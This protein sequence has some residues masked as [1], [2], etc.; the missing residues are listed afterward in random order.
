MTIR[1]LQDK[2]ALINWVTY[3]LYSKLIVVSCTL[4][5]IVKPF[6]I[7]EVSFGV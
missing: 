2:N 4:L 6:L 5:T 3:Y 1:I 7:H